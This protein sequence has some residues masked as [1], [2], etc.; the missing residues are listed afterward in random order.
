MGG[1]IRLL[2]IVSIF[3]TACTKSETK[4]ELKYMNARSEV[5]DIKYQNDKLV[6]LGSM[7]KNIKTVHLKGNSIDTELAIE[8]QKDSELIVGALSSLSLVAGQVFNLIISDAHGASTFSFTVSVSDNSITPIMFATSGASAGDVIQFDGTNWGYQSLNGLTYSG[9]WDA[10]SSF[11]S[12]GT[13]LLIANCDGHMEGDYF[14]VNNAGTTTVNAESSWFAGDWIICSN[15]DWAKINNSSAV[16]ILSDLNDVQVTT[17][18][19]G[20]LLIYNNTNSQFENFNYLLFNTSTGNATFSNDVSITGSLSVA[21][22]G[23]CLADGTNCPGGSTPTTVVNGSGDVN[24]NASSG[25]DDINLQIG[26]TTQMT[27]TSSG[28]VGIG[29]TSPAAKFVVADT[30]DVTSGNHD[31]AIFNTGATANKASISFGYNADGAQTTENTISS[32]NSLPLIFRTTSTSDAL[33]ILD[34]GNVGIGNTA[35]ASKLDVTGTVR[36]QEICDETGANCVDISGGWSSE[37]ADNSQAGDLIL[38]ADNDGSGAGDDILFNINGSTL[39]TMLNNGNVGIG[40]VAPASKLDVTGTVR[41]QEICD[42]TGANCVDISGGWSSETADNSQ[43]GDLILNA[44]NDGSGAGDDILFN[45]NGSTQMTVLNDGK[46]G[47]GTSAPLSKVTIAST[48][49]T[50]MEDDL[51]LM[52][53]SDSGAP[54]Y[55]AAKA[56]GTSSVPTKVVTGDFLGGI[57]GIGHNGSSFLTDGPLVGF[58]AESDFDISADAGIAFATM[59]A[60]TSSTKMYINSSG[61]V[62]IGTTSP[63]VPLEVVGDVKIGTTTTGTIASTQ[64]L[65]LRQDGDTYGSTILRLRNRD[66]ENGA[67]FETNDATANLVD[68][69]FKSFSAQRNIRFEARSASA[70]GGAPA[71]QFGGSDPTIPRF[72]VGNLNTIVHQGGFGIGDVSPEANFELSFNGA[73]TGVGFMVSSNDA[74]DGDI[75][76]IT[77]AGD[78][79]IGATSPSEKLHVVGNLRV[80]GSTDCTLGG[81][82]GATNCTSDERL[83][84]NITPI[85]DALE[86]I[87]K[88]KGVE[89]VWNERSIS[90]GKESIG[91]IAQDIEAV[92]PTAVITNAD[93]FLAVDYAVLVSPLIEATKELA[94]NMEKFKLMQNGIVTK[95]N[96]NS[97]AI[98]SLQEEIK[99]LKKENEQMKA[100]LCSKF[101]DAPNCP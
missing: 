68:F 80:Q 45:I 58:S 21:S 48:P 61:Y 13:D 37:T 56:R 24:V 39:M 79:G 7:L 41:A 28:D 100:F 29:D 49:S 95:I 40:N 64:E 88:I 86:K 65:V 63:T 17:P 38:N 25:S 84:D 32:N 3:L 27:L 26:G 16:S 70:V 22:Q 8:S 75:F 96:K 77:R 90:P 12:D 50:D 69:I 30:E 73:A 67:I 46:V 83:K 97:R 20:E 98:A 72:S 9:T 78:V 60:G 15:S 54:M 62:G 33:T 81:G 101:S 2:I 89:F 35:P 19:D 18:A 31:L 43:A 44:D 92:F 34:N 87:K 42:E 55:I 6:I 74:N 71:F 47:I 52:S 14:V 66:D 76:T 99:E 10:T 1:S 36:A 51:L 82:A 57:L 93:G 94:S 85:P 59:A 5:S 91:V 4:F 11:A 53:Y 23:V